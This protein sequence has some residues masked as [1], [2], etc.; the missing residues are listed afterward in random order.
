MARSAT[1]PDF[2]VQI[3]RRRLRCVVDPYLC[4]T[5]R[6]AELV[7]GLAGVAEIWLATELLAILDSWL[8]YD[9]EPELLLPAPENRLS[10]GD[11][12]EQQEHRH[13]AERRA[14]EDELRHALRA[15]LRLRDEEG[16]GGARLYWVRDAVRE[17]RLPEGLDESIVPRWEAM[18]EALDVRMSAARERS[19][20]MLAALRDAAALA[21]L[22]PGAVLLA[23]RDPAQPDAPPLL[24]R[25]LEAWH[26]PCRQLG[27]TDDLAA[28]QRNLVLQ[29]LVE[30]G[31]AGFVWSGLR[32]VVVHLVVPGR[33]R[34]AFAPPGFGAPGED[35]DFLTELAPRPIRGVLEGARAFWYDLTVE[36]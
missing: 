22:L 8:L 5:E 27:G 6:G 24:C 18:A 30:A 2:S 35:S 4:L 1:W 16:L 32:L 28:L 25:R 34:L 13:E 7:Y 33:S 29:V 31:L 20:P 3:S 10:E 23:A 15:W 21:A 36:D 14:D 19:G 26:V 11:E 9:G 17:S 12:A